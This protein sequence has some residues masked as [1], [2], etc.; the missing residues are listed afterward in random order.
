M[1]KERLIELLAMFPEGTEIFVQTCE[2][3]LLAPL[4]QRNLWLTEAW[5]DEPR[6][7]LEKPKLV[8]TA[9]IEGRERCEVKNQKSGVLVKYEPAKTDEPKASGAA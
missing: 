1:R 6:K 4:E 9:Y 5:I 3:D 7:S 2:G 8:I